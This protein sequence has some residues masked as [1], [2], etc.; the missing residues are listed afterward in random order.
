MMDEKQKNFRWLER[1]REI[2]SLAQTGITFAENHFQRQSY[3][4]LL[5]IASE[6]VK[7]HTHLSADDVYDNFKLHKGYATPKIDVRGAVF[8]DGKL[9]MIEEKMGGGW[10]MPGGWAGVGDF[11][12]ASA[13]REVWE[14]TG[15]EVAAKR[16]I[17]V[18]DANR[19]KP[20]NFFHAFKIVFLCEIISG[21]PRTS[22]E[23]IAVCFF[24]PEDIPDH[25]AGER[26]NARHIRDAF[27]VLNN[28]K[29]PIIFD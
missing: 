6:I 27:A 2:Q 23:T 11:P 24:G 1:A 15:Y 14:E 7:E 28:P 8:K 10:T 9:L 16:I 26:T 19:V 25:F 17:C 4:R 18:Y 21:S 5:E 13:E 3:N 29:L 20:L 12:A 22:V